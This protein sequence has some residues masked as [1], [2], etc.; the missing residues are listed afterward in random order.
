MSQPTSKKYF[1]QLDVNKLH[2][3]GPI[4][5]ITATIPEQSGRL[6]P[7][8]PQEG[9]T[10][11]IDTGASHTCISERVA[12]KLSLKVVSS[13]MSSGVHGN[14]EER[15]VYAID[16][17]FAGG[18]ITLKNVPVVGVDLKSMSF[19]MLIGR[20]ILKKCRLI[21]DGAIGRI[22]LEIPNK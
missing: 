5:G 11:L 15:N 7:S 10:A 14:P 6:R 3:L 4:I 13:I 1:L 17:T 22:E 9:I 12:T 2:E 21:Y 18:D 8:R 19:D 20:D 16:F